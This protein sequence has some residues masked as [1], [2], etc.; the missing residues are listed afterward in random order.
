MIPVSIV[1]EDRLSEGLARRILEDAP[2]PFSIQAS[3]P[4]M[5]RRAAVAGNSYIHQ[6][7]EGFNTAAAH[8]PFFVLLDLDR[9][10]CAPSYLLELL[11]RGVAKYMMIR[12]AITEVESWV[13]ADRDAFSTFFSVAR[14]HVSRSPDELPDAKLALFASIRKSRSRKIKEAILPSGPTASHGPDYNGTLLKFIREAWHIDRATAGSP[15]LA[16]AR[17]AAAS[18]RYP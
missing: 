8:V 1:T 12:I 14:D 10:A 13:L 9:R 18:F 4:D 17:Q 7:I 5:S 11:P 16:R 3:Y 6:K 15:S 2:H